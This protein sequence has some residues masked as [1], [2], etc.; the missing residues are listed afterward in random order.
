MER[1]KLAVGDQLPPEGRLAQALGVSRTTLREAMRAME[2]AGIIEARAGS[3]WFVREF[4]LASTA[5]KGLAYSFSLDAHNLYDLR[6][7]RLYL[8]REFL[9]EAMEKLTPE[10]IAALDETVTEM[11]RQA[12]A[13]RIYAEQDHL[14]HTRLFARVSNQLLSKLL[15]MFWAVSMRSVRAFLQREDLETGAHNH[16]LVLDAIQAGDVALACQRLEASFGGPPP[17]W[18]ADSAEE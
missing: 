1:Q 16:R 15:E 13:G 9:P 5:T 11:E 7:I 14:F 4:S 18:S 6:E 10:D 8:E 2:S 3:G 17:F 12:A